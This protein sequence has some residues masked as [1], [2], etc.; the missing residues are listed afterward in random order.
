VVVLFAQPR[1][2][3]FVGPVPFVGPI[4]PANPVFD[5]SPTSTLYISVVSTDACCCNAIHAVSI[6]PDGTVKDLCDN[7]TVAT[8]NLDGTVTGDAAKALVLIVQA[9]NK[10][11][12]APASLRK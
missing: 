8:V 12:P 6:G 10:A 3:P 1:P 4:Q 2:L 5:S 7:K 11:Y 9:L